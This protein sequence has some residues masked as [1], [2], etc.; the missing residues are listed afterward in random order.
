MPGN[1]ARTSCHSCSNDLSVAGGSLEGSGGS[2]SFFLSGPR[3]GPVAGRYAEFAA[4]GAGARGNHQVAPVADQ[5]VEQ[6]A[7]V[8]ALV[9][10][11]PQ[12]VEGLL[13]V[14]AEHGV[15]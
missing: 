10:G 13:R 4:L 2:A 9:G 15:G 12:Q 11:L 3:T 1:C 5:L 8:Q 14:A 6:L 7:E